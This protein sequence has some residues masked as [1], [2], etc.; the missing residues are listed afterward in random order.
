MVVVDP[1]IQNIQDANYFRR[2]LLSNLPFQGKCGHFLCMF[3]NKI[4]QAIITWEIEQYQCKNL[5]KLSLQL[6]HGVRKFVLLK[7]Q[8]IT[9][10]AMLPKTVKNTA[11]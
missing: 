2:I 8:V 5:Q 10:F 7:T 6:L 1:L 4:L 11:F 9:Y 3:E